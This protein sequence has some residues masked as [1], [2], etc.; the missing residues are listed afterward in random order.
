MIIQRIWPLAHDHLEGLAS[1]K[2]SSVIPRH[3]NHLSQ[4]PDSISRTFLEQFALVLV[5]I[6]ATPIIVL[7]IIFREKSQEEEVARGELTCLQETMAKECNQARYRESRYIKQKWERICGKNYLRYICEEKSRSTKSWFSNFHVSPSQG[8][9][10]NPLD[11]AC[12][13]PTTSCWYCSTSCCIWS[14][15]TKVEYNTNVG[16]WGQW[17]CFIMHATVKT[18]YLALQIR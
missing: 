12:W 16:L 1:Y 18:T 10:W 11:V 7:F 6:T 4:D 15:T 2:W 13:A 5:V 3:P 9:K 14:T 17:W 8:S